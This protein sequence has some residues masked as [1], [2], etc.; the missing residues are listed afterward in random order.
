MKILNFAYMIALF[1][2]LY[3]NNKWYLYLYTVYCFTYCTSR[4]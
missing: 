2:N 1:H 4:A 3:H